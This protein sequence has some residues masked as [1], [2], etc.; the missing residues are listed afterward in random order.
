M[1][2]VREKYANI[3]GVDTHAKTNTYAILAAATGEIKDTATFHT[4]PPSL[5]RALAWV[6]RRSEPGKTLVAIEGTNL[7]RRWTYPG[8]ACHAAGCLRGAPASPRLAGWPRKIG[9]Y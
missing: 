5:K 8:V 2:V 4:S 1:S 7:L 9:R 6:D 3:I